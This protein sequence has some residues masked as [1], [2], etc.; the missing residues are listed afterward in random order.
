MPLPGFS[1]GASIY[2]S[3]ASYLSGSLGISA[4]GVGVVHSTM[5]AGR[6]LARRRSSGGGDDP[7]APV[8]RLEP[9]CQLY[10]DAQGALRRFC[11]V[12]PICESPCAPPV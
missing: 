9:G 12:V 10:W 1:A 11:V 8:C 4:G 6:T 3:S 2:Q 7:C 5:T